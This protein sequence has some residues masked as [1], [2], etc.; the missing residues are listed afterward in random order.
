MVIRFHGDEDARRAQFDFAVNVAASKPPQWLIEAL[1]NNLDRL[2]AYPDPLELAKVES[3]LAELH[4]V[5]PSKVM[6]LA[7]ASEG[8]TLLS[9]LAPKRSAVIQPGFTEP[10]L[11][12]ID[13]GLSVDLPVAMT[14]AQIPE[15]PWDLIVIGNPTNP[16]GIVHRDID[17]L[18][19]S[20]RIIVVDEAFMDA[21]GEEYSTIPHIAAG[22]KDLIVLRSL[23]KTFAIAGLRVGYLIAHEE[24]IARL[25]KGRAHWPMG[26]LQMVAA[27]AI[28]TYGWAHT[29]QWRRQMIA[30]REAMIQDLAWPLAAHSQAP[31]ILVKPPFANPEHM[32]QQLLSRGI[33]VRRCDTFPGLDLNYWRLAVRE[34]A[35][36]QVLKQTTEELK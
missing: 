20:G 15:K 29:K 26:T 10:A 7:G 2:A 34:P 13:A 1:H 5:Q 16:T 36:V 35:Q 27:Q 21:A 18:R 19:Q 8:F 11:A 23:T 14:V 4:G 31:Y 33:A 3:E 9:K 30:H 32:R 22:A 25:Q 28:A 12:L 24:I 17:R 6:L